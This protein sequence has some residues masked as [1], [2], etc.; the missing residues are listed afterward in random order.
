MD[1][2]GQGF[3]APTDEAKA[4]RDQAVRSGSALLSWNRLRAKCRLCSPI[5]MLI[6]LPD[7]EKFLFFFNVRKTITMGNYT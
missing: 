7:V 6:F 2:S 4:G 5:L 3:L 1:D